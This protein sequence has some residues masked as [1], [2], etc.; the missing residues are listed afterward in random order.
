MAK[1]TSKRT[2]TFTQ[3]AWEKMW[4]LT[5]HCPVEISAMGVVDEKDR[6]LVLDFYIVKQVCSGASTIMDSGE[7]NKLTAR[8]ADEGIAPERMCVWWHSHAG[9]GVFFSGTDEQNVEDYAPEEYLWSVVTNHK[10]AKDVM[11]G[12]DPSEIYVRLDTFDPRNQG[13]K[14]SPLRFTHEK[15]GYK[16]VRSWTVGKEWA[17][18]AINKHVTR[19]SWTQGQS[20]YHG[21]MSSH[22][23]AVAYQYGNRYGN[24]HQSP[25]GYYGYGWED[26]IP[27]SGSSSSSSSSTDRAQYKDR[28]KKALAVFK[29][30]S[31]VSTSAATKKLNA[32]NNGQ[33]PQS[34]HEYL[35]RKWKGF[36]GNAED[37]WKMAIALKQV[38]PSDVLYRD[39]KTESELAEAAGV[40]GGAE[41]PESKEV[42]FGSM[43]EKPAQESLSEKVRKAV[44]RGLMTPE[45]AQKCAERVVAETLTVADFHAWL[46]QAIA[47]D[48]NQQEDAGVATA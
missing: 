27:S 9:N 44:S 33:H 3:K 20:S 7:L 14:E 10:G 5:H 11:N 45:A 30:C 23:G 22:R 19:E 43:P 35:L 6:N 8:L 18:E 46:D 41:K 2:L 1:V 39:P 25:Y 34:V 17:K 42:V 36:K 13:D 40:T 29:E 48:Q 31:L 26:D 12:K 24:G 47:S 32:L 37:D 28:V 38:E 15:C 16:I 4:L 21:S